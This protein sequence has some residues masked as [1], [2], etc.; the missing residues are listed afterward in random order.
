MRSCFSF[1]STANVSFPTVQLLSC[2]VACRHLKIKHYLQLK[3]VKYILHLLFSQP[4]TKLKY[5]I[6]NCSSPFFLISSEMLHNHTA[7]FAGS[8]TNQLRSFSF[9]THSSAIKT[10][11][12]MI[13]HEGCQKVK[14]THIPTQQ[15]MFLHIKSYTFV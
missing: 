4:E 2:D 8:K 15:K 6:E 3:K 13:D 1:L 12:I 7:C 11:V 5:E 10:I 14:N 9:L